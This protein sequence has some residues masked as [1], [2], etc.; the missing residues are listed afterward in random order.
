MSYN[1]LCDSLI[2]HTLYRYPSKF[3]ELA[4]RVENMFHR[5]VDVLNPDILCLQ[6]KQSSD[7]FTVQKLL[8]TFGVDESAQGREA[9]IKLFDYEKP[10]WIKLVTDLGLTPQ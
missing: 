7:H 9:F 10:I 5:E 4:Y 6:E 8:D 2:E 1:M 3:R